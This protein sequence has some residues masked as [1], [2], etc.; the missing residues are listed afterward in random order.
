M[1]PIVAAS[2]FSDREAL[3][4]CSPGAPNTQQGATGWWAPGLKH[5]AH[6]MAPPYHSMGSF[7]QHLNT[8]WKLTHKQECKD[9]NS[10]IVLISSKWSLY[11]SYIKVFLPVI[12]R[13]LGKKLFQ[14]R[15]CWECNFVNISEVSVFNVKYFCSILV[16][17]GHLV[18]F[19]RVPLGV[20]NEKRNISFGIRNYLSISIKHYLVF[21]LTLISAPVC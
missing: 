11:E 16:K 19:I 13:T 10:S 7:V 14:N 6:Y 9:L 12:S 5:R 17:T 15:H 2:A 4:W 3:C 8:S 20:L 18:P 1:S 21:Y